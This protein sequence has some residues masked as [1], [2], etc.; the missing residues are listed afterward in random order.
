[1]V[2]SPAR[3]K[4]ALD[5]MSPLCTHGT[6]ATQRRQAHMVYRLD[7]VDAYERKLVKHIEG[8]GRHRGGRAQQALCA[9]REG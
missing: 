8:G 9:R 6:S 5:A 7:A 3:G 1:M 4:S 2:A